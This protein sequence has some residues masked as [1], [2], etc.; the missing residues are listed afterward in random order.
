MENIRLMM[1]LMKES[2]RRVRN[3]GRVRLYLKVE[4]FL[5]EVSKMT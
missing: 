4:V 1:P 2:G 3:R 5:K